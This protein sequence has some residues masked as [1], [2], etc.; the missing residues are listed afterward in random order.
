MNDAEVRLARRLRA[1]RWFATGLLLAMLALFVAAT[2]L[3]RELPALGVIRAFAEAAMVGALADWFAVTAL[4]RHPLGL[5]IPH[6]AIVP[7][8]KDAIGRALAQFV[9]DHFLVR[10]TVEHRLARADLAGRVGIWLARES[11]AERLSRDLGRALRW[12]TAAVDSGELREPVKGFLRETLDASRVR[13]ALAAVIDVLSSGKHA[14]TLIDHLVQFGREQLERSKV[15]I[16]ERIHDRSPW[17]LPKFVD[18]EIYDRLVSEFERVL[19]EIG[20]DPQHE[21]RQAFNQRLRSLQTAIE[22]DEEFV[23]KANALREELLDHPAV[24]SYFLDLGQRLRAY[25]LAS[26]DDERSVLRLG[27]ERQ[28][29]AIGHTLQ[30]DPLARRRLDR[31]LQDLLV[32]LVENYRGPLSEI[33]SETVE[34]WDATATA[35][36]IELYIGRDLQFI[37]I[38]GTVVGGLVGVVIYALSRALAI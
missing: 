22:T 9:R 34:R 27:I 11:N 26:L 35:E 5:P 19:S 32:Y 38:N 37:R 24:R 15:G 6:T 33:I 28:I 18:E 8:R 30:D 3:E 36:R 12:L 16:R 4:F 21:A 13:A 10:E 2:V 31:W 7:A 1:M 14:Q 25:V 23:E 29:R 20:D 17:W